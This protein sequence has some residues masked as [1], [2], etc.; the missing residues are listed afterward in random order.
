MVRSANQISNEK[1]RAA[2]GI[3]KLEDIQIPL[4]DG[5]NLLGDVYRPIGAGRHPVIVRMGVYG[6]AFECGCAVDDASRLASEEREDAWFNRPTRTPSDPPPA[7]YESMVSANVSDW[8]PRGYVCLRV[9][10]R[11]LGNMPGT[12]NPFSSEEARDFY[13]VIEWAAR[14]P[15]SDGNI[16]VYGGSYNAG[17]AWNVAGL[18]PPSLK[19]VI[20][21]AGD[22]DGYRD[23]INPGG[24]NMTGFLQSWIAGNVKAIQGVPDKEVVDMVGRSLAHPFDEREHY[25]KN[26]D[27]VCSAEI[28]NIKVPFLTS[29]CLGAPVHGRGGSEAFLSIDVPEKELIAVDANY[30]PFMYQDCLPQ[31]FAFFDRHLKGDTTASKYSPVTT[32]IRTGNG[33][34]Y[35]HEDVQWPLSNTNFVDFYLD[36]SK[37]KSG[38]GLL[39]LT[40]PSDDATLNYSADC[41]AKEARQENSQCVFDSLPIQNDL[42]IAGPLSITLWVSASAKDMDVYVILRILDSSDQE[43]PY[44]VRPLGSGCPVSHGMLKASH[45]VLDP[46]RST[47]WRPYHTHKKAD[48]APLVPD[49]IVEIQVEMVPTTARVRRGHRLQVII[50]PYSNIAAHAW[51]AYGDLAGLASEP[52]DGLEFVG[53]RPYDPSYHAKV[54][55][56]IH[57]GPCYLSKITIP[58]ITPTR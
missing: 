12:I 7:F 46:Q 26:G 2:Q 41:S 23:L 43:V 17:T 42:E 18:A 49:E 13:E 47:E 4:S 20:A 48:Y 52:I 54:E 37:T 30:W 27:V 55:N 53:G 40:P 39:S 25:G 21:F 8:V 45:R 11:G 51:R 5:T 34:Y 38:T 10:S 31:Q 16:G 29:V 28:S 22:L 14:Q 36:G 9:D 3:E 6:R 58:T 50:E 56:R 44:A 1:R 33:E 32:A 15:W 57:T 19:A 24:L 35:W